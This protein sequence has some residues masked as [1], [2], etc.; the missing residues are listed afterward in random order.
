MSRRH[1]FS[2]GIIWRAVI[3]RALHDLAPHMHLTRA[4]QSQTGRE[5]LSN[6]AMEWMLSPEDDQSF[7]RVCSWAGLSPD[8]IRGEARRRLKSRREAR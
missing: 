5:S 8:D 7:R 2:P 6:E 4:P 1:A 3:S